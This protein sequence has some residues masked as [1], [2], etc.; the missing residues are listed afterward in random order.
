MLV[1]RFKLSAVS[2]LSKINS[3]R[4]GMSFLGYTFVTESSV[5]FALNMVLTLQ[6]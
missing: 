3:L 6:R 4:F 2:V 1:Y 5:M